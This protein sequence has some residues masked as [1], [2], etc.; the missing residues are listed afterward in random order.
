MKLVFG[1]GCRH[2]CHRC[3]ESLCRLDTISGYDGG[4]AASPLTS[5]KYAGCPWELGLAETQQALAQR[6]FVIRSACKSMVV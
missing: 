1:T 3:S 6:A 4:T 2:H 5:V